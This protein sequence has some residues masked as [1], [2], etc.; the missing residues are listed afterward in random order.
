MNRQV[1]IEKA[2]APL[3]TSL[4]FGL[5][6][7]FAQGADAAAFLVPITGL[8]QFGAVYFT[9]FNE[10]RYNKVIASVLAG[11]AV[12]IVSWLDTGAFNTPEVYLALQAAVGALVTYLGN[13]MAPVPADPQNVQRST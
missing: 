10:R 7:Y 1:T 4:I 5:F 9:R 11:A 3:V 13:Y 12:C 6:A 8:L 2:V